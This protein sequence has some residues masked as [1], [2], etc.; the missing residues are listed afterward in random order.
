MVYMFVCVYASIYIYVSCVGKSLILTVL[1]N[2][3]HY[4]FYNFVHLTAMKGY[5]S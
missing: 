4:N 3:G 1:P 2:F 5:T